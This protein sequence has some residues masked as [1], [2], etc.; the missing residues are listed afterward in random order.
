[1]SYHAQDWAWKQDVQDHYALMVLVL[2]AH[3]LSSKTLQCNPQHE[4][5]AKELQVS[6]VTVRRA[7]KALEEQ[8]FIKRIPFYSR[9][10]RCGTNY[11]L[12]GYTPP[13][14]QQDLEH[15]PT[16]QACNPIEHTSDLTD[17]YDCSDRSVR[18]ISQI[19]INK[20][21]KQGNKQVSNTESVVCAENENT[22]HSVTP[23]NNFPVDEPDYDSA[24]FFDP[25]PM[26]AYAEEVQPPVKPKKSTTKAKKSIK[27]QK[28]E[29][30]SED[31]LEALIEHR[32]AKGKPMTQ[33]ALDLLVKEF[34]K[35]GMGYDEAVDFMIFKG[36]T[37]LKADWDSVKN[38][39]QTKTSYQANG[40]G[41]VSTYAHLVQNYYY[42]DDKFVYY[43]DHDS[44]QPDDKDP[45]HSFEP[46]DMM[47]LNGMGFYRQQ[48]QKIAKSELDEKK[49]VKNLSTDS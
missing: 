16:D 44:W 40:K 22:T 27:L 6:V 14:K 18:V 35:A 28:P 30:M 1:M 34:D 49:K 48:I 20:E 4:T 32:K 41:Y 39:N 3:H 45:L 13:E 11:V 12:N 17:N 19:G 7:L 25:I 8:G 24:P 42:E 5:L 36:W 37:G 9:G 33:R 23:V 46:T 2:L 31:A 21:Y 10:L 29:G 43:I 15:D 38:R 47:E 26:E